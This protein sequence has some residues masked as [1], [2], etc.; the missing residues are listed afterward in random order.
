MQAIT[1][2]EAGPPAEEIVKSEARPQPPTPPSTSLPVARFSNRAL[3]RIA[4]LSVVVLCA[5]AAF[6]IRLNTSSRDAASEKAVS[7]AR[8]TSTII[9]PNL[10]RIDDEQMPSITIEPVG[11]RSFLAEKVATGK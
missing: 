6:V 8:D 9:E 3:P 5:L 2:T 7:D 4:I 1:D 10:V 11:S